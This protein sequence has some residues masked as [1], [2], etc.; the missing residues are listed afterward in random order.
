MPRLSK[1]EAA[2]RLGVSLSTIDRMIQRGELQTH[3]EAHG[4][5]HRLWV[6]LDDTQHHAPE[7]SDVSPPAIEVVILRERVRHLEELADFHRQLLKDADWRYQQAMDTFKV[8]PARA[9]SAPAAPRRWSW[10]PFRQLER[11]P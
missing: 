8:L 11:Q 3:K 9:A 2:T 6:L 1:M 10:W 5:R 4:S 7:T